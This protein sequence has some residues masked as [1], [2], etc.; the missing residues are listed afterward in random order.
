M[1]LIV[2]ITVSALVVVAALW[3][4]AAVGTWWALV[5][6]M[7]VHLGTTVVVFATVAFVVTGHAPLPRRHVN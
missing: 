7:G 2:V 5:I 6:A 4:A 3:G 1:V